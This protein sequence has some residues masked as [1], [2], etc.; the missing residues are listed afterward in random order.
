MM[1]P[2]R[3]L[4]WHWPEV[5][6]VDGQSMVRVRHGLSM[7]TVLN[8]PLREG[9]GEA[10]AEGLLPGGADELLPKVAAD[11]SASMHRLVAGGQ[12]SNCKQFWLK[13]KSSKL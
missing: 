8:A 2:E 10:A 13:T 9:Q 3:S 6:G 5:A 4:Y 12:G 11:R 7:E 1:G